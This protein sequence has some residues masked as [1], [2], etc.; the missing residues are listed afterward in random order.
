M[1][2]MARTVGAPGHGRARYRPRLGKDSAKPRGSEPRAVRRC[3]AC[4]SCSSRTR[5][6]SPSRSPRGCAGRAS[7]ST[8][9]RPAAEALAAEPSPTSCCSTCGCRTWTASPSVASCARAPTVPIIVVTAR[10]EEVDRVVGLELGADDYVVKPF[11]LRELI[12][13]IRAVDAAERR[14]R[15]GGGVR[16]GGLEVDERARRAPL[17]AAARS[18]LTAEGVRPARGCSRATP[19]PRSSRGAHARGGVADDWYG[20]SKTV[21]VHVAALRRKLGDPALDRDGARHRLPARRAVTPPAAR[22]LPRARRCSSSRARGAARVAEPADASGATSSARSSTTRRAC[23]A[24]RGC[25]ADAARARSSGRVARIA[26]GYAQLDSGARVVIV[27]R[28]GLAS[29]TRSDVSPASERFASRPE[30]AA[31]LR[32]EVVSGTR[33][34][35]TLAHAPA[36][37]RRAGRLG[38]RRARRRARHVPD[39]GGRRAGRTATG[40]CSRRSRRSCSPPRRSS[41][42]GSRGSSRSPLRG[43]E[44]AAAA[45]GEGDLDARAPERT[46]RPRCGRSPGCSTTTAAKLETAARARRSEFVADASHELRTPL[47]ALRLAR[48]SRPATMRR[49]RCARS[50][51]S[52][53]RRRACS[54]SRGP[55]RRASRPSDSTSPTPRARARRARRSRPSA[56]GRAAWPRPTAARAC[57]RC[58]RPARPGARQPARERARRVARG[59]GRQSPCAAP[60]R[61]VE[62]HVATT[63][64][65]LSDGGAR[66][67]VRPLL[68]RSGAERLRARPRDRR[69]ARRA[70]TAARS[71]L[72]EAAGGGLDAVV[73]LRPGVTSGPRPN[74]RFALAPRTMTA[75]RRQTVFAGLDQPHAWPPT[76]GT[77]RPERLDAE[78]DTLPGVGPTARR[79]LARLGLAHGRRPAPAPAA[80]L[81]GSRATRSR[82]RCR[83][84][85]GGRDRR[86]GAERTRSGRARPA[87]RSSRRGRGRAAATIRAVWFNQPW[88]AEQL[89]PGDA[90]A[91]ARQ[92]RRGTASTS[93]LRH[94]R[95]RRDR[96][97]RAGLPGER[98]DRAEALRELARAALAARRA[99]CSTRCRPSCAS[100]RAAAAARRARRAALPARRGRGRGARQRLAFE[101]LLVLQLG[102]A[103]R[104]ARAGA[105]AGAVARR[106]GRADRALPRGAAVRADPHQ[107]QAIARDRRGPGAR[108][109]R[110]SGCCRA[111]SARARR[112]SRS[113]RSCARSRRAGRAR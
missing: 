91:A 20:S 19:E 13:R 105:G 27:D 112:S 51:G 106:A 90:R 16:V 48:D 99:T 12:A 66:A 96:R 15:R 56:A 41:A 85:R 2:F 73:R 111:T 79:K 81:R 72:R 78:L 34:S 9:R 17:D 76:R 43:L 55:T 100:A 74:V 45:V 86:R 29:S 11:G 107:E 93:A 10:G 69:A 82:S 65:G 64:P 98:G 28:R 68:E 59:R 35:R 103:R 87:A 75:I 83:R 30:I 1:R 104:A 21:D 7:R 101:E 88:L 54:R 95:E 110:C 57:T 24:R 37:R 58:A 108:P 14:A 94:R 102:I 63:G 22:R 6:R 47:T 60:T 18:H 70:S 62:L 36:L 5:T 67:G 31:A 80:P 8:A 40:S 33:H 53:A 52:A 77:A 71:E 113:T 89:Q 3:G 42:S 50:T 38:R 25:A 46:G 4:G 97:L 23:V 49:R 39:L 61:W 109:C 26:Y 92:L 84:R 32:G 44:R